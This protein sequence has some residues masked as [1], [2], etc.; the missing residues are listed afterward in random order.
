M[1]APAVLRELCRALTLAAQGAGL[2]HVSV[3]RCHAGSPAGLLYVSD[4][5]AR[6]LAELQESLAEGPTPVAMQESRPVFIGDLATDPLGSLW[7]AFGGEATA[8]GIGSVFVFPLQVGAVGLGAVTAHGPRPTTMP[9]D[10][11]TRMLRLTDLLALALLMP[12]DPPPD[13]E[14]LESPLM[15]EAFAVTNQAAGM[16]T[17]QLG[18]PMEEALLRLY[19]HAIGCGQSVAEVAARVVSRTLVFQKPCPTDRADGQ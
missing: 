9:D 4:A 5:S 8:L 12:S 6:E 2:E 3:M 10:V 14:A 19:A 16:I 13:A 17:V 18:I 15:S 1:D 7:V 11:M